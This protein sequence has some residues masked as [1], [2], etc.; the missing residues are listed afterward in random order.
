[1]SDGTRRGILVTGP[2]RGGT[3]W[4]GKM[5]A[6]DR[7]VGYIHEPFN[8]ST[9]AGISPG[10]FTRYF[11]YVTPAN[12]SEFVPSLER[13]LAFDYALGPELREIGSARDA[14]RAARDLART[15]AYRLRHRR[16]LV[17]DPIAVFSAEWLADRFAL[18][19][20]VTV[21]NPGAFVASFKRLGWEHR[22]QSFLDEPRLLADHLRGFEDEIRAAAERPPDLVAQAILLWR[23]IHHV[24]ARFREQRPDWTFVRHEDLAVDPLA[25]FEQLYGRAGLTF[26]AGIAQDIQQHSSGE[27]P[28]ELD[29][30]HAV[31]LDSRASLS[32]WRRNLDESEIERVRAGTR[33]AAPAFYDEAEW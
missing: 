3:T 5:L 23:V 18:D 30:T 31:R 4:V 2:P 17:K 6:L 22:F 9:P 15:S 33:D 28:S 19:V 8:P 26:T 1:M 14:A 20:I 21:R 27:N 29:H 25:G 13:T 32:N 11:H 12:E 24:L 7:S 16:P 10:P